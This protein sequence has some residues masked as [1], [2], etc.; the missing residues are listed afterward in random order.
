MMQGVLSFADRSVD[1]LMSPCSEV[2]WLEIDEPAEKL[3][4]RILETGHAA[5][6]V[7]RGGGLDHIVGVARAPDLVRDLLE[8]G[9]IE[10]KTL[11]RR[12]LILKETESALR[13]IEQIRHASV[14]IAIVQNESGA[15]SG[16]VS[17]TDILRAIVGRRDQSPAT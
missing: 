15:V 14:Q 5:Y 2:V 9:R 3:R 8:H 12:P 11:E 17:A 4:N 6:P 13:A 16:V 10:L 7:C 1:S